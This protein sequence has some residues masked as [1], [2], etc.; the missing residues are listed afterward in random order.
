M[1]RRAWHRGLALGALMAFVITGHAWAEE[2][3]SSAIITN[4]QSISKEF[5]AL[6]VTGEAQGQTVI[7]VM[8]KY[9][10]ITLAGNKLTVVSNGGESG[11]YYAYGLGAISANITANIVNSAQVDVTGNEKGVVG[12]FVDANKGDAK[13]YLGGAD[14]E[15]NIN[16]VGN[17][18]TIAVA[19]DGSSGFADVELDGRIINVEAQGTSGAAYGIWSINNAS[20]AIGSANSHEVTVKAVAQ[21]ED[22][23]AVAAFGL[24]GGV[25]VDGDV[26][27]LTADGGRAGV[28]VFGLSSGK[29]NSV[30]IGNEKSQ[31]TI[32]AR[33]DVVADGVNVGAVDD[34]VMDAAINGSSI[35]ISAA[36]D[37]IAHG[38]IAAAYGT[39]GTKAEK[40][41]V[42]G[43]ADSEVT[44]TSEGAYESY[45]IEASGNTSVNMDVAKATV[46][47]NDVGVAVFDNSEVNISG[48]LLIAAPTV[49]N[50]AA[51][52]TTN[53]NMKGGHSTVLSGDI[54]FGDEYMDEEQI[55]AAVNITLQGGESVWTG[56]SYQMWEEDE[57]IITSSELGAVQD[58]ALAIN[59]GAVWNVTGDSFVNDLQLNGGLV[60]L[61]A[62]VNKVNVGSL[63]GRR[64]IVS[65]SGADN[66]FIIQDNNNIDRLTAT[67]SQAYA[68]TLACD[69]M[70]G[71]AQSVVNQIV[72]EK[73]TTTTQTAATDVYIP[74]S[75]ITGAY[76]A[77]VNADGKIVNGRESLNSANAGIGN[78][79]GLALMAWRA[80]N[81]D[82]NKRL[83]ELRASEGEHGVWV[84]MTRGESKYKG[85]KN[86]YNTYQLGYDEK[87]SADKRWTLGAAFSYT[88]GESGLGVGSGANKHKGLALYGSYLGDD[89]SFIDLIA[90]YARLEH[91]FDIRGGAGSGDYDTN[92]YSLSA[93]YGKRFTQENGVWLEPQVELTYGR[94]SGVNYVSDKGV[95]VRQDA[96]DSVVGRLGLSVGKNIERGNVYARASYLYDFDGDTS[97]RFSN[98]KVAREI[99]QDI[100][101]GWWEVGVGANLRLGKDTHFYVDVERTYGGDVSTPWQW[102]AGLRY[103]F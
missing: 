70:S 4:N 22:S 78:L 63:S 15:V 27:K 21:D 71:A 82:M 79:S 81:N 6:Y 87:L 59:D 93:E 56:S 69:D 11:N 33:G 37:G 19:A 90:K 72:Y 92:G 9:G 17:L 102:N 54:V 97:L 46:Q 38:I 43:N 67:T 45:G 40:F 65:V 64:G 28:G 1:K 5:D 25:S 84:R 57:D 53:I 7:G 75:S 60:N 74:A 2:E 24:G 26:I 20:I 31:V 50:A 66:K 68:E 47:S 58:F 13:I 103:S 62:G 35:N 16:T 96:L 55:D 73:A 76:T 49:I 80:E 61:G 86:Q 89:G 85:V 99:G 88:D 39:G 95:R 30:I 94:V 8:A 12:L 34:S 41:L 100:G 23:L 18:Q 14:A 3:T 29:D 48:D 36:S 77:D 10:D 42:I 52:S 44:I 51:S 91:D 83:G 101:G 98:G 32:D